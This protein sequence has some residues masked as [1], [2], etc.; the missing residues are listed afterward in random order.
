[1]HS[2]KV[3]CDNVTNAPNIGSLFRIAD[4]FG[5]K[6][7]IFCGADITLGKRMAKTSRS[8]EKYVN[9][10]LN[11]DIEAQIKDLKANNYF[12]IALEITKNSQALSEFQL[13]TTQPIALI[14]GDENFGVSDTILT[15]V[16]AVVHINMYGNNSSMNVAQAT[17]IALYEITKQL[18]FKNVL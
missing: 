2:I 5:I 18:N 3:I 10:S 4:A 9:H 12:L 14:L 13:R 6:E 1:M 16:D 8:T 15:Q 17:S 7:L 11:N